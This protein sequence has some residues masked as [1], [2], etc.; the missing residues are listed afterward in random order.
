MNFQMYHKEN[1]EKQL[2]N[3]NFEA[4]KF[5]QPLSF[6]L[7]FSLYST[8]RESARIELS[9]LREVYHE[10]FHPIFHVNCNLHTERL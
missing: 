4:D 6:F 5:C 1:K 7:I 10:T 2:L 9:L 3:N 8:T